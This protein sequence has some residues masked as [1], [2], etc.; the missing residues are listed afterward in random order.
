MTMKLSKDRWLGIAAILVAAFF[1]WQTSKVAGSNFVGDPGPKVFPYA[2]CILMA[3]CGLALLLKKPVKS[4]RTF[5]TRE[6]LRRA[7]VLFVGYIVYVVL[8]WLIGLA[9]TLPIVLFGISYLFSLSGKAN[10]KKSLLYA[11]VVAASIYLIYVVLLKCQVP[12]G[13]I[14]KLFR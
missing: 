4:T 7:A 12:T 10:W 6:E 1:A 2:G 14:W 9:A 13:I 11:I 3:L 8:L 5:M